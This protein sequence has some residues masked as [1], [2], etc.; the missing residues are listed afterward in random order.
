MKRPQTIRELMKKMDSCPDKRHSPTHPQ[1]DSGYE[2]GRK[3]AINNK[4]SRDKAKV[5]AMT[6]EKNGR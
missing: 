6:L 4:S 2:T 3:G 5:V 1:Q